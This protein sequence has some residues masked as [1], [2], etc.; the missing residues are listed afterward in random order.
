MADLELNKIKARLKRSE[1]LVLHA[2]EDSLGFLTIGYGRLIDR[3]RGGGITLSEADYLLENDIERTVEELDLRVPMWRTLPLTAQEAIVDMSF[4]MGVGGFVDGWP[5]TWAAIREWR[6][7]D[8]AAAI[9]GSKYARQ[10]KGRAEEN[11]RLF[12]EALLQKR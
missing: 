11:A 10:V 2:Y 3:R 12:E 1:G 5:N 7:D 9:R 6:F 4:N 8:V